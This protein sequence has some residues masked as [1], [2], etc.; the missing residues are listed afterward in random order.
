MV[1]GAATV[2]RLTRVAR[3]I[4][5]IR[6][7]SYCD[8]GKHAHLLDVFRP[9][10]ASPLP[11]VLYV[12]GGGF[13]M[14]SKD[15][16]HFMAMA[17]ARRGYLVF[18]V[19]YRLAPKHPYP[20]ALEDVSLAYRWTVEHAAEFGGDTSRLVLAGESA[21]ANV[22]TCSDL[23]AEVLAPGAERSVIKT[24]PA[25]I[26]G[27]FRYEATITLP[28]GAGERVLTPVFTVQN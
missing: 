2:A 10:S 7:V 4:E 24:V 9:E 25:T 22:E 6:D 23:E 21:G 13:S 1:G 14:L 11:I 28:S 5:V 18:N 15:T 16:H 8:S 19:N 17:F 20:A 27:R 26:S 12:H 3:S